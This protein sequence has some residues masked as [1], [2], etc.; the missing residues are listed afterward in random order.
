MQ[1]IYSACGWVTSLG[2]KE[3]LVVRQGPGMADAA[4]PNLR[5]FIW[6]NLVSGWLVLTNYKQPGVNYA[7][8]PIYTSLVPPAGRPELDRVD[9]LNYGGF[10]CKLGLPKL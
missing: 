10:V 6:F 3:R 1:C 5:S 4:Q 7:Y 8:T 2:R 9:V